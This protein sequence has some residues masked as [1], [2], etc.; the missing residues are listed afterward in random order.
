MQKLLAGHYKGGNNMKCNLL[1]RTVLIAPFLGWIVFALYIEKGLIPFILLVILCF[2]S[3]LLGTFGV[4]VIKNNYGLKEKYFC[5]IGLIISM[6][7]LMYIAIVPLLNKFVY[8]SH[9][10][11]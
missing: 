10:G 6:I 11:K 7:S 1:P 8:L 3:F 4:I 9:Q 2:Y 5:F